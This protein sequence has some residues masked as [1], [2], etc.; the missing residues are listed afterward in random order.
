[1][2]S[3]TRSRGLPRPGVVRLGASGCCTYVL[4][5]LRASAV[6]RGPAR[7]RWI[8]VT[9][10]AGPQFKRSSYVGPGLT[11]CD[12]VEKRNSVDLNPEPLTGWR[13]HPQPDRSAPWPAGSLPTSDSED[14]PRTIKL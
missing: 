14:G 13:D 6:G 7:L 12:P 8:H 3:G 4:Y 11:V 1:M 5:A 2:A 10:S 9:L